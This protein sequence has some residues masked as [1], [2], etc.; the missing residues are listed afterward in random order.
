M[1]MWVLLQLVMLRD[2]LHSWLLLIGR[3]HRRFLAADEHKLRYS[4]RFHCVHLATYYFETCSEEPRKTQISI[5]FP[6]SFCN[7]ILAVACTASYHGRVCIKRGNAVG[8]L[9]E[10]KWIYPPRYLPGWN[11]RAQPK[12]EECKTET[13]PWKTNTLISQQK[14]TESPA[15]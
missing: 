8:Q 3:S 1:Q 10:E 12:A 15:S 14:L 5:G 7:S 2:C 13:D 4:W 9:A 11:Q 6:N